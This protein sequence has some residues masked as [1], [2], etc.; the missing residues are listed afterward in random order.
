MITVESSYRADIM[1]VS[2]SFYLHQGI[3]CQ[4]CEAR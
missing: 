2:G 3:T 1:R 4:S